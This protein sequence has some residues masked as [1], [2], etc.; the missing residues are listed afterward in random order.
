M[1]FRLT[2][3]LLAALVILLDRVT[4]TLVRGRVSMWDDRVVIPHFFSIVHSENRGAAFGMFSDSTAEL[5][6]ILLIALS[7]GVMAFI[8]TLLVRPPRGGLVSSPV[9]RA[10]LALILGGAA[11]NVWDRI[12]TGSVTDFLQFYFGQYQFAAF[13]IADSAITVGAGLLLLDMW[14]T[15]HKNQ[16]AALRPGDSGV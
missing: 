14:L 10:G 11:G 5:R 3:F 16:E 2:P 12:A 1:K 13:N 9:L 15:R 7:L 6:T 4:K 8:T